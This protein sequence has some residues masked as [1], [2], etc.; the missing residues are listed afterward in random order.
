MSKVYRYETDEQGHRIMYHDKTNKWFAYAS[1]IYKGEVWRGKGNTKAEA[2]QD[3]I[4]NT[5]A[6]I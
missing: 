1:G 4:K 6:E 2:I 3:S 5:E